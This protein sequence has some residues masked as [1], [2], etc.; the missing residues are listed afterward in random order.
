[1]TVGDGAVAMYCFL[2]WIGGWI[3]RVW[4]GRRVG[5]EVWI[6]GLVFGGYAWVGSH[7]SQG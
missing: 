3:G 1:M 7:R 5:V 4:V 2:G 6:G